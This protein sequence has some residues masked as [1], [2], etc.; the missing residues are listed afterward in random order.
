MK[1]KYYYCYLLILGMIAGTM[2][3]VYM[4]GSAVDRMYKNHVHLGGRGVARYH[5]TSKQ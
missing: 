2:T 5:S 3:A 1:M 4:H